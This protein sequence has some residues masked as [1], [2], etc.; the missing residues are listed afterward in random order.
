MI[1][2][3][4][5][6]FETENDVIKL[7]KCGNME[8][9]QSRF[10][11]V[12]LS[13]GHKDSH[14]GIKMV[15]SS[16]GMQ[17]KLVGVKEEGNTLQILQ[18]SPLTQVKTVF[19]CY[20]DCDAFRVAT[21]VTNISQEPIVLEEVSAFT[22]TGFGGKKAVQKAENLYFTRFVQGHHLEAQPVT[23]SFPEWGM[24][25]EV[26]QAQKRLS[27][28]NIGSWSSKEEL[29]VGILENREDST[30]IMFQLESNCSWYYEISD[31]DEDYYIYLGGGNLPHGG[32]SEQLQPGESYTTPS[33]ALSFGS[34]VNEAVA[35]LTKCRRHI[36]GLNKADAHLPVHYNDYMHFTWCAP[37]QEGTANC[38]PVAAKMGAEYYVIDCGWHNEEG[39]ETGVDIF[40]YLGQW[41]ESKRRFPDGLK[42][43]M[44]LIYSLGM[45]PGLWV[46]A[47]VI[48][49]KCREMLDYYDADCFLQRNGKPVHVWNR[50]FLDYRNE[51]VRS[52]M[53]E[54][55][56]Q[57]IEDYGARYIKIDYNQDCGVGTDWKA[58]SFGKG[59]EDCSE[60][61]LAFIR[62][63][64]A[65]YPDVIFEACSSGG[66]RMDY[67]TLS[68]LSLISISDQTNYLKAP[69]IIGN[70]LVGVL[71]EQA[72]IWSYPLGDDCKNPAE[73]SDERI[74]MNMI[75]SFLGRI[76]LGSRLWQLNEHQL[77]V[78]K[79][80]VDYYNS[81]SGMKKRAVPYFPNG[82]TKV[83]E[84]T[85]CSGLKDGKKL[86]LAVWVLKGET[87]AV[88]RITE[89]IKNVKI[90]YPST[91]GAEVE[92]VAEGVKITL[93]K[94]DSA[95]FLEIELG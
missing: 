75:N 87:T 84:P 16:E 92:V 21:T 79:E 86:Y 83:G 72:A 90:G 82:F 69:Y 76:Y 78:V 34:N 17:L 25:E 43:T 37:T 36:S 50:Y 3:K 49:D 38:A 46:E 15:N 47:E 73:L 4:N 80:G 62:E 66:M 9:L 2:F 35:E 85:V 24:G 56:R 30:V 13:G 6:A 45:K 32:W 57:M 91:S 41:K 14:M 59:L 89:P 10:A 93:P 74:A 40:H 29:P 71:P 58:F 39:L 61:Y 27:F 5:L 8:N 44:E 23:H 12:Q 1:S 67:K 42:K 77:S 68:E 7:V 94:T 65:R 31:L 81:L 18:K 33:V 63:M 55:F 64:K 60:A 88:A 95:V 26:V 11:E 53:T 51:K 28:A 52:Y 19:T 20:D 54:V 48:G 70:I 22:V